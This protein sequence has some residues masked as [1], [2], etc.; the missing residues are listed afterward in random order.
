MPTDGRFEAIVVDDGS[1]DGTGDEA[2]DTAPLWWSDTSSAAASA[3]QSAT[4]GARASPASD[5]TSPWCPGTTST[6]RPNWLP[7]WTRSWPPRPTTSRARAGCPAAGSS[8]P[9]AAAARG[10]RLYSLAF[11]VLVGR[12]VTDATN[13]FRIFR[14]ELLSD[15]KIDLDQRWLDSY[16]LE[17]YVLYRAIT[18]GLPRHRV[19]GHRALPRNESYTKMRGLKDWW[20]LFRPGVAAPHGGQTMSQSLERSFGGAP[21]PRDRRRRV[22]RL[23][24]D[25]AAGRC[26]RPGHRARRPVHR[27]RPRSSRRAPS[28]SMAP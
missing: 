3:R 10:T 19:P 18:C 11:S 9:S 27:A 25:P 14:P 26:R 12:R 6:S 24:R 4:A 1:T 13:G 17:P 22:R 20:R 7:R 2:R 16:D 5:P 28:S 8:A 21:D 23:G 15:S